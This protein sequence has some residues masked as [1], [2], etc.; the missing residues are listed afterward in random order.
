ML[1]ITWLQKNNRKCSE[2]LASV[3]ETKNSINS[4]FFPHPTVQYMFSFAILT[5]AA[6]ALFAFEFKR[7]DSSFFFHVGLQS[8]L[9][10]HPVG[11]M[12]T[13]HLICV[14]ERRPQ[15]QISFSS[16]GGLW[17]FLLFKNSFNFSV[18]RM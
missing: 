13:E 17:I 7:T 2:Q 4:F 5:C 16:E 10:Q 15:P 8:V 18:Y 11:H 14:A 12:S 1:A 3:K 9:K 6:F